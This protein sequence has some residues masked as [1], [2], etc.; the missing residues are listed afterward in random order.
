MKLK[1]FVV[2][3]TLMLIVPTFAQE[4][5]IREEFGIK[6]VLDLDEEA[7]SIQLLSD[8]ARAVSLVTFLWVTGPYPEHMIKLSQVD[9]IHFYT[10][11]VV[12]K[13]T[14]VRFHYTWSGPE[15]L[16]AT[17]DWYSTKR[18]TWYTFFFYTGNNWA[19]GMYDLTVCIEQA[20]PASG[21]EGT[22]S[23]VYRL[24]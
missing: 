14:N 2:V 10:D 24:W 8:K 3:L 19:K 20:S 22:N 16:T 7:A 4:K 12:T 13:P 11:F 9:T 17:S 5:V 15:F 1:L 18:N 6:K 21:A 23:C